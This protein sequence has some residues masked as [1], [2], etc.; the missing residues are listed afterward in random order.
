MLG[1][2]DGSGFLCC[3]AADPRR[4]LGPDGGGDL[5][6]GDIGH[7]GVVSPEATALFCA[8]PGSLATASLTVEP[9]DCS[10]GTL[11][12]DNARCMAAADG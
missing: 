3:A 10:C 11:D 9:F 1:I 12:A 6:R 2:A 5:S 4:E 7:C 8:R